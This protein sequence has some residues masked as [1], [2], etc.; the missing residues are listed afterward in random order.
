MR[1]DNPVLVRWEFASEERLAKRN[2]IF[3]ALVEGDNPEDIAFAAVA[4]SLPTRLLD[5]GCGPGEL[6]ERFARE[7]GADVHAVDVSPRM[8]E[9]TRARGID[10]ELGDAEQLRFGD[11]EFDCVFAGWVL[12][13]V[14]NLEQAIAECARVLRP[15]GRLVAAT[16]G[17]DNV[18]ELWD[19]IVCDEPRSPLSFNPLNG[20]TLLGRFFSS[21]EERVVE[22]QLV[23]PDSDSIRTYVAATID[24]A[25]YAD[26][27]PEIHEP[28]RATTRHTVFVAER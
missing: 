8:V 21:V 18:S 1:L 23:F 17:I 26:R 9:L 24:R 10:A 27:V 20:A 5:V 28:F 12:Y 14:P 13:H 11:G 25:H 16:H 4:E 15:G 22:A 2:A 6:T 3:R 19:L 7:L